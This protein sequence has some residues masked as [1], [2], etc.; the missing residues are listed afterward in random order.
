MG[1]R[2]GCILDFDGVIVDSEPAHAAAKRLVL[3]RGGIRFDPGLFDAWIG[4]PDEDFFAFVVRELAPGWDPAT[5]LAAKRAAYEETID[6]VAP[7]PG[8]GAFLEAARAAFPRLA[9]AT[10][11]SGHDVALIDR[12]LGLLASVDAVVTAADTTRHKPDPE[13]YLVA[14]DR[15]GLRAAQAVA[16]E[17]SPNGISSA[18]GAG[19]YVVGLVGAFDEAAL[20]AAGA[21]RTVT[22]LV[23]LAADLGSLRA[24]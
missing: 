12:R 2:T 16:V 4:R 19:L 8:I 18:R 7:V 21:G 24:A 6:R 10:S 1:T 14:L 9:V 22:S 20:L 15:L 3:E 17:D 13:P 5:L 23:A 11:A